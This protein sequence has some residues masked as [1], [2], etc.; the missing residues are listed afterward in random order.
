MKKKRSGLW[1]IAGIAL[2]AVAFFGALQAWG[3]LRNN[4]LP[5]FYGDS[6]VYVRDGTT[7]DD[8]IAQIKA[9]GGVRWEQALRE[10]FRQKEVARYITPGHYRVKANYS[11]VYVARMLNNCW[12]TPIRLTIGGGLRLKSELAASVGRQMRVDSA[13]V[14]RALADEVFLRKY[15]YTPE[16]VYSMILPD[17]YEIYWDATLTDIFTLLKK[18]RDKFWNE[19]RKAKA[20]N[21]R[22]TPEQVSILASIVACESNHVPEYPQLAGVYINR[23]RKGMRLQ[24]CPTVAFCFDFKP[25]R[26]LKK[27]L[28][29][30]SPYNTYT[31]AGL[32]PGPICF[33]SKAAIDAVLNAD[34]A[35]GYLYFC[36]STA[37]DGTNVFSKT[38]SEHQIKARAYQRALDAL[39]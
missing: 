13:E 18:E 37:F 35:S 26:I 28:Q 39:K 11:C 29:V 19:E 31:H 2:L 36:A 21:L 22:L 32:P 24:A 25:S 23:Y 27:H 5:A 10:V 8:V 1:R 33:P 9:Q 20:K 6:E 38:Y 12:Q 17:T 7:P 4:R 16:S 30:K 15:G 34:T 14:A 3:W